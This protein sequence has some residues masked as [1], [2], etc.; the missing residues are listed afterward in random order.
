MRDRKVCIDTF[1]SI[2][3]AA[4]RD[5]DRRK[6]ISYHIYMKILILMHW[7]HLSNLIMQP[8]NAQSAAVVF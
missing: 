1:S 6:K 2:N 4:T 7:S 8:F 5:E 3:N